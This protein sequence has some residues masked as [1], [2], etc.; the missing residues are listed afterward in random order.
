MEI[1]KIPEE[2]INKFE[3]SLF[4][5]IEEHFKQEALEINKKNGMKTYVLLS[6]PLESDAIDIIGFF[7][8]SFKIAG[9]EKS[10]KEKLKLPKMGEYLILYLNY[11]ALNDKYRSKVF[12]GNV[13]YSTILMIEF[14]KIAQ[15]M[16]THIP[17]SL[18]GLH[19]V[20]GTEFLYKKFEFV[21]IRTEKLTTYY[22]LAY[23]YVDVLIS[24]KSG[25]QTVLEYLKILEE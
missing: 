16:Y 20:P 23:S 11:F 17:S 5:K 14:F 7:T 8:Y 13:K 1:T 12:L 22:C 6:G 18:V 2:L 21:K 9:M 24:G 15:E 3:A 19:A 25:N 10:A 4:D